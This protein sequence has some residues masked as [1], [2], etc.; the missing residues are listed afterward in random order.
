MFDIFEEIIN[1]VRKLKI[2]AIILSFFL[3]H[4]HVFKPKDVFGISSGK[5]IC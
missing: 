3:S 2:K 1:K 5:K 4:F